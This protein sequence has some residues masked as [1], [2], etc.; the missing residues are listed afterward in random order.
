MRLQRLTLQGFKSFA[1]KTEFHFPSGLTA[2]LGPNGAGKSNLAEAVRWALGETAYSNLRARRTEDVIFAGSESRP[3][4]GLGQVSLHFDNADRW[5]DTD[6]SEVVI[7]RRAH[8]DG[9]NEYLINGSRVRLRDIHELLA[10]AGLGPGAQVVIGQ[11]LVDATLSLRPEDRRSLFEEAAGI[12]FYRMRRQEALGRLAH[13]RENMTRLE[14][15]LSEIRPR[16]RSLERQHRRLAEREELARRLQGLLGQWYSRRWRETQAALETWQARQAE[17]R[18]ALEAAQQERRQTTERLDALRGELAGLE[19]RE[20][21]VRDRRERLGRE[22]AVGE[23]RLRHQEERHSELEAELG[24]L[25]A[26]RGEL[27]GELEELRA[28]RQSLREPLREVQSRLRTLE[29]GVR[30]R[31][32]EAQARRQAA[33]QARRA[34]LERETELAALD[35]RMEA[36]R[37]E[38]VELPQAVEL[39]PPPAEAEDEAARLTAELEALQPRAGQLEART[40]EIH[41]RLRETLKRERELSVQL[42]AAQEAWRRRQQA[43]EALL[44]FEGE[45]SGLRGLIGPVADLLKVPPGLELAVAAALESQ[46]PHL[47]VETWPDAQAVIEALARAQGRRATV[48]PLDALR[49]RDGGL[50]QGRGVLGRASDLVGSE[51]RYRPLLSSLLGRVLVVEDVTAGRRLLGRLNGDAYTLVTVEGQVLL[52]GGAVRGGSPER[53]QATFNGGYRRGLRDLAR[54]TG[55]LE[56]LR[57]E[58]ERART[59]ARELAAEL[60]ELD[61]ARSRLEARRH[62]LSAASQ[63]AQ[64]R[65]AGAREE[66]RWAEHRAAEAETRHRRLEQEIAR[67]QEALRAA[68]QALEEAR[69]LLLGRERALEER[70]QAQNIPAE[71]QA[72]A[73]ELKTEDAALEDLERR[74][75]A[76][77]HRTEATLASGR[78]R[79]SGLEGEQAALAGRL[80]Q[81]RAELEQVSRE[82]TGLEGRLAP[83][84]WEHQTLQTEMQTG[85][86]LADLEHA[87]SQAT[88]E[89]RRLEDRLESLTQELERDW[90]AYDLPLDH[91]RQLTLEGFSQAAEG[92]AQEQLEEELRSTKARLRAIGSVDPE[93]AREYATVKERHDHL[94]TQ[95]EDLR[96][97]SGDLEAVI[98]ELDVT[99][100]QRFQETL[101]TVNA[102]FQHFFSRLF[103]GGQAALELAQDAEWHEAGVEIIAR[104]PGKRRQPLSSLSGGERSLTSVALIFAL[105]KTNPLPFTVLDEVDAMLDEANVGRFR[106]TLLELAREVQFIVITHNRVTIEA[107]NTLYGVTMGDDGVSRVLSLQLEEALAQASN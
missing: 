87:A 96:A 56:S 8:R 78:E 61:G 29:Q 15:I 25:E 103:D 49:H 21:S 45:V 47:A 67:L 46:A 63:E 57:G 89:R 51:E 18:T 100:R 59:T 17:A 77:A 81:A 19:G 53:L 22:A 99:M 86:E 55:R 48:W 97:A 35:R 44:P 32:A 10:R 52:E 39:P 79:L 71:L 4:S 73:A 88:L 58:L 12:A 40:K 11:G 31:E 27:R 93:M 74:L 104:P 101:A 5:L 2:I 106:E 91:T 23:E 7:T 37:S 41:A 54:A 84:R 38:L 107:A 34:V 62:K 20:R 95:L 6:F 60:E 65:L 92:V 82:L 69:Q 68:G 16:L 105:L 9:V 24:R 50:P 66:L 28:R 64:A 14:D 85:R 33:D 13:T 75:E 3:R 98:A 83:L 90:E 80:E 26:R 94:E 36:A 42:D 76:D 1:H 43:L 30:V 72:K 70:E 102:H